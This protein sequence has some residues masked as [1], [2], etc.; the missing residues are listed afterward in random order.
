MEIRKKADAL[1]QG[2]NWGAGATDKM[3]A[4]LKSYL[5][6]PCKYCGKTIT[7]ENCSLDHK[8]PLLRS[9]SRTL[10]DQQSKDLNDIGNL[11]FLC[12]SCNKAKGKIP[13]DKFDRLVEFLKT[14]QVLYDLVWSRLRQSQ[15][16][17]W[18]SKRR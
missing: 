1:K 5:G 12:K 4:L 9:K 11:H 18:M 15:M 17:W 13:E 6:T 3:E 8:Y 10:S 16:M 14:D 2:L 7:L